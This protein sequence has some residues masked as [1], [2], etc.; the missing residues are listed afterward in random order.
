M[1]VLSYLGLFGLIPLL[2][3][4]DDPEIQWHAKNGLTLIGAELAWFVLQI[5]LGFIPVLGCGVHILACGVWLGF[6]ILR[7]I[8]MVKAV[9][10]QRMRI[11]IVSDYAEKW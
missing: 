4:K 9:Q 7:I 10:G 11:P 8:C 1:L 5:V 3:K 6:V 2:T